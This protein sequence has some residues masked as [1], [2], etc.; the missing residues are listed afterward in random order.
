MMI[1]K[2]HN[3][4]PKILG[5]PRNFFL[6][7]L[8]F[9]VPLVLYLLSQ[10][11]FGGSSDSSSSTFTLGSRLGVGSGGRYV[12]MH[13]HTTESDGDKTAEEQLKTASMLGMSS[14][15]ITDHD[16]IRD[17]PRVHEIQAAAR[18]GGVKVG[19][20]VEIT[21]SWV[22]KEHH[23]LGYFPDSSWESSQLSAPMLHLQRECAKVKSSR[24]TR[25]EKMVDWLNKELTSERAHY[26]FE[27]GKNGAR[28]WKPLVVSEV[29]AWARDNANLAEPTSLGRPHFSK[30]L[31]TRGIRN[32]LIFGPR[33]GSGQCLLTND[34]SVLYDDD[35][36][37]QMGV[38]LE[39]LMHSATL[40]RRGIAFEPLPIADAIRL[41]TVAGGRAVVAHPPT[42]GKSWPA[43]FLPTFDDLVAAGLWGIEGY[44]SEIDAANHLLIE[45]LANHHH[46]KMTGGSDNH[47][48]L[49]VYAKLGDVHR[50]GTDLY[51]ALEE[52]ARDG[53]VRS[54]RMHD[55]SDF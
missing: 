33:T 4:T 31:T 6:G 21:V 50:H 14:L 3:E 11:R 34:G 38:Q 51:S 20:G 42:L 54:E 36:K 8:L 26:Y 1:K 30:Y 9:V 10:S 5:L 41:I 46:L 22:K 12:D 25:N 49:K 29:A 44:S 23:L 45:D 13:S 15:W 17:I 27:D 39:A 7:G 43:K 35:A 55:F 28:A 47:G 18:A 16:M 24:E 37:G 2:H 32:A 53:Q 48:T 19:F 40:G 52:W